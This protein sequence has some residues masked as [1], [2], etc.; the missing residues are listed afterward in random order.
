MSAVQSK[1]TWPEMVVRKMVHAMGRRYTLHGSQLPGRP[2]L[3]FPRLRKVIFVNGCYWHRHSGCAKATTPTANAAF[4]LA[5]FAANVER[6]RRNRRAL[7]ELGWT[8]LT[9]WQCELRHPTRLR[10]KVA[11]FLDVTR[12]DR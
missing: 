6:D 9:V 10:A 3:V 12:S 8:I 2:D 5:K 7:R 1:H 11:R 4:W